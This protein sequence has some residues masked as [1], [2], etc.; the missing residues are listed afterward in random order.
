MRS[1][2]GINR[3]F[4]C[5]QPGVEYRERELLL[6]KLALVAEPCRDQTPFW[7]PQVP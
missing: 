3:S 5:T 1:F 4:G 7:R 2:C 6:S